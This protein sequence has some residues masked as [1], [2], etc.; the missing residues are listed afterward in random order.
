MIGLIADDT[1]MRELGRGNPYMHVLLHHAVTG[2]LI[3]RLPGD[4]LAEVI[5]L[6]RLAILNTVVRQSLGRITVNPITTE[7]YPVIIDT[8]EKQHLRS[9]GTAFALWQATVLQWPVVTA[10]RTRLQQYRHAR[11][12]AILIPTDN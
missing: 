5:N 10:C 2:S 8:L 6:G 1:A 7:Q 4:N 9:I 3:L 11:V 12:E